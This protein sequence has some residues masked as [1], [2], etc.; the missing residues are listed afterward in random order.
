MFLEYRKFDFKHI[1]NVNMMVS[2]GFF[3]FYFD[4]AFCYIGIFFFSGIIND[5][6]SSP[7]KNK[8]DSL[9]RDT[10]VGSL[11]ISSL[12]GSSHEHST[13]ASHNPQ[14]YLGSSHS[15]SGTKDLFGVSEHVQKDNSSQNK[16]RIWSMADMA[17]AS[18]PSQPQME[19]RSPVAIAHSLINKSGYTPFSS[20]S[21]QTV[22]PVLNGSYTGLTSQ[23][24]SGGIPPYRLGG[25]L[26]GSGVPGMLPNFHRP[27]S[28][29]TPAATPASCAVQRL[30]NS[31]LGKYFLYVS[32]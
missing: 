7:D 19:R 11:D 18:Q 26:P 21:T 6:I 10:S 12:S 31:M 3:T 17:T 23:G 1:I 29:S 32:H 4:L 27:S 22:P 13:P 9:L 5:R 20:P 15:T 8:D 30:G 2:K 14:S 25:Y 16:P 28:M 24:S